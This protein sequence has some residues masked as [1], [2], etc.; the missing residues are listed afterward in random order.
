M[1]NLATRTSVENALRVHAPQ[2]QN[3]LSVF[4]ILSLYP[5]TWKTLWA[6]TFSQWLLCA[7]LFEVKM[8]RIVKKLTNSEDFASWNTSTRKF[9]PTVWASVTWTAPERVLAAASTFFLARQKSVKWTRLHERLDLKITQ[10]ARILPTWKMPWEVWRLYI[11]ITE[12]FDSIDT[13][14]FPI[15]TGWQHTKF[16]TLSLHRAYGNFYGELIFRYWDK[17]EFKNT[18]QSSKTLRKIDK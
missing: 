14:D 2:K 16:L 1:R 18:L 6:F 5:P 11:D 9:R 10:A 7:W 3:V 12:P 13:L 15:K 17:E 8:T 4:T